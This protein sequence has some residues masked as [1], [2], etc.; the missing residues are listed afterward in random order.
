MRLEIAVTGP[1]GARAA[2]AH[3]ADRVELCSAL[4]LGGLTPSAGLVESVLTAGLPVHVLIRCR[5]GDFVF[6]EDEVELMTRDVARL[7]EQGVSGV[8]VGALTPDGAVDKAALSRWVNAADDRVE[9]TFHRAVDRTANPAASVVSI[10][11]SGISRVL[12]SGGAARAG[13]GAGELTRM[14]LAAPELG[15]TAGGG[16]R[17]EDIG[18]LTGAGVEGIHLSAKRI[19]TVPGETGVR[20]G[21]SDDGGH[22]DTDP[23]LVAAAR[24]E[25]DAALRPTG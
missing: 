21:V 17:V 18:R 25:L 2:A 23:E 7:V 3:G 16:V 14:R 6:S 10:A 9:V 4:E 5:P 8:V 22:W 19:V 15:I 24:A 1:A 12:S 20:L 13:D 11:S